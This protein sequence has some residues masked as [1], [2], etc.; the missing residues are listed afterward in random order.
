MKDVQHLVQLHRA[1]GARK[2]GAVAPVLAA[3]EEEH[4]HAA[5]PALL[6]D[7][8]HVRL[9]DAV[10]I[11]ALHRLHMGERRQPV[12]IAGGALEFQL[13]AGRLPSAR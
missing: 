2:I 8:E 1:V 4:L 3:A 13:G 12:A 11:D 6:I 5:L 9:L 10:R 7:G